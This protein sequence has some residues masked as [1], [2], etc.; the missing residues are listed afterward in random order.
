MSIENREAWLNAMTDAL[1][2]MFEEADAP[3]PDNVRVTCGFPS[4]GG[5]PG[6][7]QVLGECWPGD[8][9]DDGHFEVFINPMRSI[10]VDVAGTLVHELIHT[11]VGTKAGHRGPFRTVATALGLEGKMTA[12]TT[13]PELLQKLRA[14]IDE[15]GEY[16]HA[17]LNFLKKPTQGTRMLKITCNDCGY[18]VRTSRK[19]ADMGMPTC[20]CGG[21]MVLEEDLELEG[22]VD[23]I[24]KGDVDE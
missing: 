17:A 24:L 23:S 22:L 8:K 10:S 14:I 3:I 2:P 21:E 9:S 13:G 1:K 15:I 4:L 6:A 11:A 12:T 20:C 19:W 7:K 16:P 5:R 18:L